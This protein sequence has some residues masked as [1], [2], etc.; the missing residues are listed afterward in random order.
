[1]ITTDQ[2]KDAAARADALERYLDIE[3]KKIQLEEEEL[4]T[5]APEFWQDQKKAEAQMKLVK[6]L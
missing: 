1:M 5:Q 2:I 4:K 3:G 6:G